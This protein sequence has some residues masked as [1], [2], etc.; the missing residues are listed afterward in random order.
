MAYKE[1]IY[2]DWNLY[3]VD[4]ELVCSGPTNTR[5]AYRYFDE[6]DTYTFSLMTA[7]L[8]PNSCYQLEFVDF[9]P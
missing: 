5:N 2:V 9:R 8:D 6:G 4:G 7:K 1:Y 3:D